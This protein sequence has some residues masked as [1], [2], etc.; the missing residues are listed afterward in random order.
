[1][2]KLLKI[3]GSPY[4]EKLN[5][6]ILCVRS[7]FCI[8]SMIYVAHFSCTESASKQGR[9]TPLYWPV[10]SVVPEALSWS[11][12][13]YQTLDTCLY[14]WWSWGTYPWNTWC[15]TWGNSTLSLVINECASVLSPI[16]CPTI[17]YQCCQPHP[18]PSCWWITRLSGCSVS[19]YQHYIWVDTTN[20]VQWTKYVTIYS[21]DCYY[22]YFTIYI[23]L[24]IVKCYYIWLVLF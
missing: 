11:F 9:W 18:I 21:W 15:I 19:P 10:F 16:G 2:F 14:P 5:F 20:M 6:Q 1:M 8:Q 24:Y 7:V 3:A 17:S 4:F 23:L 12:W 22:I 13:W